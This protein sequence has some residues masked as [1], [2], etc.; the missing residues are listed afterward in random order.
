MRKAYGRVWHDGLLYKLM[1]TSLPPALTQIIASFLWHRSFYVVAEESFS[2]PCPIRAG[3]PQ[4]SCLLPCLFA[5][6]TDDIPTL[7]GHLEEWEDDVMLTIVPI[8]CYGVG[9]T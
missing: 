7:P 9:P 5:I 1:N 6:F 4:S 3:V 2:A 8:S